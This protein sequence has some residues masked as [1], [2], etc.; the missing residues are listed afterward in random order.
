M[1]GQRIESNAIKLP[2]F[3][4]SG[5]EQQVAFYFIEHNQHDYWNSL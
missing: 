2:I 3:L 1:E 5:N 4:Q